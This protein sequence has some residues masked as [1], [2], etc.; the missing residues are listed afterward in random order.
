MELKDKVVVIIGGSQ[1]FGKALA[2]AFKKENAKVVIASKNK[3]IL[4]NTAKEIDVISFVT[5]VTDESQVIYL[6]KSVIDQFG[7]IDIWVNSAGVFR[8]FSTVD[9]IDMEKAHEIFDVNFFGSVFGSRTAL[10]YM[11][12]N[13]GIIMNVLSSAALDATRSKNA[14]LYAASKWALRGYVDALRHENKENKVKIYSV[15]PGGMKTHLHDDRLPDEFNDF[16]EPSYVVDKV[17]A[18]LKSIN[19]E[20]DLI[21]KRPNA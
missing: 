7:E 16:M 14:K 5:D 12:K 4:E 2:Q 9:N 17:I 21:I 18:N 6:S 1:G 8:V 15:Y 10:S 19:P 11:K 13:G 3:E 20:Y